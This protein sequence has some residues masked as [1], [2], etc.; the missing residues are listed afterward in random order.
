MNPIIKNV[1]AVVLGVIVGSIVNMGIV[2]LGGSIIPV[3]EGVVQTDME[4]YNNSIHLLSQ[5]HF[6]MP[7]LAH[8]L[9]TLVVLS[10]QLRSQLLI[11]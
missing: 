10:W 7:F 11:K 2:V 1:G 3:P 9:G 6:I 8:A 4:S 5:K